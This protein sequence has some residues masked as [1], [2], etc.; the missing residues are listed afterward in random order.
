VQTARKTFQEMTIQ[1][2]S[3]TAAAAATQ[4]VLEAA[5]PLDHSLKLTPETWHASF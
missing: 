1:P 4:G 2:L 5:P 3:K